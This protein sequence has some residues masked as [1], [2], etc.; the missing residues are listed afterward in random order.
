MEISSHALA[1][2]R[3]YAMQFQTAVFTNLTRD[4]LDFHGTMEEYFA[5]KQQLFLMEGAE[6]PRFAVLNHD[7]EYGRA[8]KTKPGT[9]V[10]SYGFEKGAWFEQ[11]VSA[12]DF[13]GSALRFNTAGRHTRL[14][15]LWQVESTSAI[16]WR[17]GAAPS[18]MG[19]RRRR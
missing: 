17:R 15:P 10:L 5:A 3:V 11:F 14:S 6:G 9:E 7:D 8:V 18:P 1:L 12:P 2:G 16:S 13:R 4:H 19:S